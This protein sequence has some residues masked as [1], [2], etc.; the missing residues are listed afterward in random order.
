MKPQI[1]EV[2]DDL[3]AEEENK[4]INEVRSSLM[5]FRWNLSISQPY[6]TGI[7]NLVTLGNAL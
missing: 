5:M 2:E 7:Q 4:L 3:A 1:D 6:L